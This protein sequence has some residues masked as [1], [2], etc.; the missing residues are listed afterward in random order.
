MLLEIQPTKKNNRFEVSSLIY[1][2]YFIY[3]KFTLEV[4]GNHHVLFIGWFL[5]F[6]IIL[7]GVLSSSKRNHH[8]LNGGNDFQGLWCIWANESIIPKPELRWF[9][10]DA[11][12]Y[13][14][15]P[16]KVTTRRRFGRYNLPR[17]IHSKRVVFLPSPAP[18]FLKRTI[19]PPLKQAIEKGPILSCW[20]LKSG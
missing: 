4:L 3:D 19:P 11:P 16:F 9:W 5:S 8:F 2:P 18:H 14:S 17:C 7:V 6:T 20:W 13:F 1:L 15:P 12:Y 10:W